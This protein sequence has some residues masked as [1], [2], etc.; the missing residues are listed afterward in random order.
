MRNRISAPCVNGASGVFTCRQ[1]ASPRATGL[2]TGTEGA[3]GAPPSPVRPWSSS[4]HRDKDKYHRK[5]AD[6]DTPK[7]NSVPL[8][9][10]IEN[11]D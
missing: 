3:A 9:S 6:V 8:P 4:E 10:A 11:V 2:G 5:N 1:P 7:T